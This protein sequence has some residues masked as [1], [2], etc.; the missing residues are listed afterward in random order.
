MRSSEAPAAGWYPDPESRT[1]LRWWDGLDWTNIRRPPPL[2][3]E[4]EASRAITEQPQQ[5]APGA[6]VPPSGMSRADAQHIIAIQ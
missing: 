6:P 3:S 2:G 4:L 1:S 5:F